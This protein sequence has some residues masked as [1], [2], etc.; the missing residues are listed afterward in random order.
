[1]N[2]STRI[3]AVALTAGISIVGLTACVSDADKVNENIAIAAENFEVQRTIIG[4]SGIT[5]KVFLYAEGRCS[6]E[7]P[8][9]NR[10]DI[11]CKTSPDEYKRHTF[12]MGDQDRVGIFQ[13]EPIDASEYHTRI[14]VKPQ[15]IIP[16][17][18]IKVG[19]DQ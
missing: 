12:I 18:D 1:M 4:Q 11:I 3:A 2:L 13:E 9:S 6:F 17:F 7:Y 14:V 5:D 16:E 10:V 8:A 19:E 15:N